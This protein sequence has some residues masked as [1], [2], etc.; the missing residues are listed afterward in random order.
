MET[1][2][3]IDSIDDLPLKLPFFGGFPTGFPFRFSHLLAAGLLFV[4]CIAACASCWM[5]VMQRRQAGAHI[6]IRWGNGSLNV[7][8]EGSIWAR[9]LSNIMKSKS[10]P[11]SAT[12]IESKAAVQ[13]LSVTE[14]YSISAYQIETSIMG[15]PLVYW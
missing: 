1:P 8:P 3:S 10:K 9:H 14:S 6:F 7:G 4:R 12:I 15:T 2:P 11:S 5:E 13:T